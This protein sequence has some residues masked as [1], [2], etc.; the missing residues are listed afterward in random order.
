MKIHPVVHI[1]WLK[2]FVSNDYSVRTVEPPPEPVVT[3][4][5]LEYEV[6]EIL[7][8]KLVRGKKKFLIRWKGYSDNTWEPEENLENAQ[9]A[10]RDY[11]TWSS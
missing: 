11:L 4:Q 8:H 2:K 10:L 1:S 7:D 3:S 5:G 9:E 6:E